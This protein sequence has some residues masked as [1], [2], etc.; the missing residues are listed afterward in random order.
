MG[1]A[2]KI[3]KAT[4]AGEEAD[5]ADQIKATVDK[6]TLEELTPEAKP[7]GAAPKALTKAQVEQAIP[8]ILDRQVE[9]MGA[10]GVAKA[11]GI[12]VSQVREIMRA[13]DAR[14]AELTA[15]AEPVEPVDEPVIEEVIR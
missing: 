3:G 14:R 1:G 4:R 2:N 11:C 5:M 12:K 15:A 9:H 6:M 8:M 10:A 13:M 7:Q